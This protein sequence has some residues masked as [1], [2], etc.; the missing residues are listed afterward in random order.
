MRN[1]SDCCMMR[2]GTDAQLSSPVKR[3]GDCFQACADKSRQASVS[4]AFLP[5]QSKFTT[6]RCMTRDGRQ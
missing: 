6:A 2:K 5:S 1:K 3:Q 4:A